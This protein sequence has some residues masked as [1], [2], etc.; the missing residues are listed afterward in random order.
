VRGVGDRWL[1][2]ERVDGVRFAHHARVVVA[3]GARAGARGSVRLLL[4]VSPEPLYLVELDAG[5]DLRVRQSR[6]RALA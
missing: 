4:A 6:L 1:A 5:G 2:D 3:E